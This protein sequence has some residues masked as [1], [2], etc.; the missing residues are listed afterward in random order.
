M[1]IHTIHGKLRLAIERKNLR[2]RIKILLRRFF[3]NQLLLAQPVDYN[4]INDAYRI[5][6]DAQS[7]ADFCLS[8]WLR[9]HTLFDYVSIFGHIPHSIPP[10]DFYY[11]S[12]HIIHTSFICNIFSIIFH[13][14]Y[15]VNRNCKILQENKL[16]ILKT[17]SYLL[18]KRT[19]T[20]DTKDKRT[21]LLSN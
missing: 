15:Y 7:F 2:I 13:K 18:F 17:L 6:T 21:V 5:R 9:H 10:I 14:L 20:K 16:S 8:T 19:V 4:I 1:Y 11:S 3:T 12:M